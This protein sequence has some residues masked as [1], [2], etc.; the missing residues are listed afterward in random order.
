MQYNKERLTREFCR[1]KRLLFLPKTEAQAEWIQRHLFD[2]GFRWPN[3]KAEV[4]RLDDC[5]RYGMLLTSEGTLY[6][7]I[8]SGDPGLLCTAEQFNENYMSPDMVLL[9]DRFNQLS[10]QMKEIAQAVAEIQKELQP[11]KLDK[12]T[13]M[14]FIMEQFNKLSAKMDAAYEELRPAKLDKPVFKKPG[15]D[16]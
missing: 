13:Q 1:D 3:G 16:S 7:S 14:A 6:H 11:Q 12:P 2:M 9:M 8:S 4:S 15:L 5:A 10:A